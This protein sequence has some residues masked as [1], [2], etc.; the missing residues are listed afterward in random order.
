MSGAGGEH[1]TAPNERAPCLSS[2]SL[3]TSSSPPA[4]ESQHLTIT[5]ASAALGRAFVRVVGGT[6][7]AL[8]SFRPS[9][10]IGRGDPVID[11]PDTGWPIPTPIV[12]RQE[13]NF[14]ASAAWHAKKQSS[15]AGLVLWGTSASGVVHI[16][17]PSSRAAVPVGI[18]PRRRAF[19]VIHTMLCIPCWAQD[20]RLGMVEGQ[21]RKLSKNGGKSETLGWRHPLTTLSWLSRNG[22]K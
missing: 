10:S 22:S 21:T 13:Q 3:Q 12:Y 8:S 5:D 17:L 9:L 4:D 20:R 14:T 18:A 2:L 7:T 11:R 1:V 16:L 6:D 15:L 19:A